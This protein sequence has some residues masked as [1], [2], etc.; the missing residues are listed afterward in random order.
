M[1]WGFAPTQE[2]EFLTQL[3]PCCEAMSL[4]IGIPSED[5]DDMGDTEFM[6]YELAGDEGDG[7]GESKLPAL[8]NNVIKLGPRDDPFEKLAI[9]FAF[10]QSAK[11]NVFEA[12]L[13]ATTEEIKPIPEQ[14]CA[15]RLCVTPVLGRLLGMYRHV[16]RIANRRAASLCMSPSFAR[17]TPRP[18]RSP[19]IDSE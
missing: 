1:L 19:P 4:A 10:A 12:A 3:M 5:A 7:A 9:S 13:E 6:L 15:V 11:L 18:A 2:L 17:K 16:P 14:L 8:S